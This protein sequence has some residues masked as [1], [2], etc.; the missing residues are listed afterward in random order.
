[1]SY[2]R[3]PEVANALLDLLTLLLLVLIFA[4]LAFL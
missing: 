1:M 4:G 3:P 2:D